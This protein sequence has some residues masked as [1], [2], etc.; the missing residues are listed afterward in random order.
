[1]RRNP[2]GYLGSKKLYV[3]RYKKINPKHEAILNVWGGSSSGA[4]AALFAATVADIYGEENFVTRYGEDLFV[5]SVEDN[6]L[7]LVGYAL[8]EALGSES[9][10]VKNVE[11]FYNEFRKSV[12]NVIIF[13]QANLKKK[14]YVLY[15]GLYARGYSF[16]VGTSRTIESWSGDVEIAAGYGNRIFKSKIPKNNIVAAFGVN[17]DKIAEN[18]TITDYSSDEYIVFTGEFDKT[19]IEEIDKDEIEEEL[20]KSKFTIKEDGREK[21]IRLLATALKT[22][23]SMLNEML[24]SYAGIKERFVINEPGDPI[25]I[26]TFMQEEVL[27]HKEFEQYMKEFRTEMER[28][29]NEAV[30]IWF[31]KL[32]E[33][34][35][36]EA[37]EYY[38]MI[39]G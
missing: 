4:A 21:E 36:E 18:L 22:K 5:Q 14:Q 1:M 38:R 15:R 6:V 28:K 17:Y 32:Y 20:E 24:K 35:K 25:S 3:Q 33:R 16:Y 2:T 34:T 23:L 11:R 39:R 9:K 27:K 29:N 13:T 19:E 31:D 10:T 30:F 12:E 37:K 7:S 26:Y 8:K